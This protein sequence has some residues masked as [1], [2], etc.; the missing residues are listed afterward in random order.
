[1]L[2]PADPAA[3]GQ[4]QADPARILIVDDEPTNRMKMRMAVRK[5]GHDIELAENGVEAIKALRE[6]SFDAVLLDIVMPELDGFDV[7]R[8][9][10]DYDELRDIPVIVISA[11]DDETESV[12]KAISLGAEDFLPK[13]FDPVLLKARLDAS[14]SRKRYRDQEREYLRRVEKLTAAAEALE[15]GGFDPKSLEIDDLAS[16]RDAL[17]R[18]AAVFKG[19]AEEIFEREL[20]LRRAIHKLQGSLLVIAVVMKPGATAFTVMPR[21]ATS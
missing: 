2:Q 13:N 8:V 1:M 19:M 17:G 12:V 9:I 20:R 18:L 5:L 4:E 7:L 14:L 6:G 3:E 15:T 21:L 11:L 16:R 10:R